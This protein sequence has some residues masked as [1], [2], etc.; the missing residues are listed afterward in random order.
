M[1]QG[2]LGVFIGRFQPFHL[3]H[4][5]IVD[6]NFKSYEKFLF[7][8]GSSGQPRT[9]R[10]PFTAEER[11]KV[12]S[13]LYPEADI[14]A[15]KDTLY[16]DD[17]WFSEVIS[18]IQKEYPTLKPCLL[19]YK[20]DYTSNYLDMFLSQR[21]SQWE[22]H[23]EISP[24]TMN[25]T[26]IREQFFTSGKIEGCPPATA[27]FLKK[28][29][30]SPLYQELKETTVFVKENKEKWD[31]PAVQRWGGPIL[32]TVDAVVTCGPHILLVKRGAQ[33]GQGLLALP[34][35]Y[36][37]SKERVEDGM[38]RELLEETKIK[39]PE[40]VLR[41]CIVGSKV[42]DAIH[43]SDRYRIIT[44]A[45]HIQLPPQT[46]P[47]VKGGD[48]AKSASWYLITDIQKRTDIMFEDHIHIINEFKQLTS[49]CIYYLQKK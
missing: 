13:E 30:L 31:C 14:L 20:K 26:D 2:K 34:G 22:D 19:G 6:K 47:K 37:G 18:M 11:G 46:L 33:P 25:A 10:N 29:A 49:S 43:R 3:G 48:D 38:I 17:V 12:I 39:I 28:F 44:H 21:D 45:Y 4:K 41:G 32:V 42:F 5:K 8:I 23:L 24:D 35:G 7:I 27:K 36:L 40:K 16:H 9:L 15:M 1:K